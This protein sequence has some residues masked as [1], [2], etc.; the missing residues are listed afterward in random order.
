ME[1]HLICSTYS[2]CHTVKTNLHELCRKYLHVH[3]PGIVTYF[4]MVVKEADC[5]L[6]GRSIYYTGAW[7]TQPIAGIL[8]QVLQ[9][10]CGIQP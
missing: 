4:F 9:V 7:N 5:F 3:L 10:Y 8:L 1:G 2:S 6:T